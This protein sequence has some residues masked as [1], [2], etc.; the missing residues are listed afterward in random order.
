MEEWKEI[1]GY[2]KLYE[3]STYGNIRTCEGKVTRTERH[4][5]RLWKQRV[6]KQKTD[7]G[8]YK[9]VSLWKDG[10]EKTHL[11]HRLVSSTFLQEAEGKRLINHKDANPSNNTVNN[12][13]WCNHY[14]NL[15]HAYENNLNQAAKKTVLTNKVT[16]EIHFFLS[17][18]AASKFLGK[19]HGFIHEKIK[20]EIFEYE[21]Y[22]ISFQS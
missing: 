22:L 14:E 11:V 20:K 1:P 2:E 8:G 13:E 7:K 6:L 21:D 19:H 15:M 4:G 12:L 3:A 9:R 16:G 17:Q 18:T 5:E 10:T